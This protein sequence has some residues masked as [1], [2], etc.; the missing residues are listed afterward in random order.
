MEH[1]TDTWDGVNIQ[2]LGLTKPTDEQTQ[3]QL[4]ISCIFDKATKRFV[5]TD[6]VKELMERKSEW[7]CYGTTCEKCGV[8]IKVMLKWAK[9]DEKWEAE[10]KVVEQVLKE[11]IPIPLWEHDQIIPRQKLS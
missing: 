2:S 10:R 7:I 1:L 11:A 3:L 9:P 4:W 5:V 6:S 8:K